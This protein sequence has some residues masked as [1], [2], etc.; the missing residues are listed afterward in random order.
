[1]RKAMRTFEG[2]DPCALRTDD[3]SMSLSPSNR[4]IDS[5][6]VTSC[7]APHPLLTGTDD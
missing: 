3:V 1:M 5:L 2:G 7:F 6:S 4:I